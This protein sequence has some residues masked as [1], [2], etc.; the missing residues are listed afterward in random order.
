MNCMIEWH[1]NCPLSVH[2]LSQLNALAKNIADTFGGAAL[3]P[4][5]D[6]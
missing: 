1:S 2:P 5:Y 6:T 4:V 3:E